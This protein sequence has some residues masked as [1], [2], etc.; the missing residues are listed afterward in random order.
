VVNVIIHQF[1]PGGA[2][3]AA[4]A[5]AQFQQQWATYRKLV[6]SDC[7]GHREVG[8]ILRETLNEF[9]RRPFASSTLP[10]ATPA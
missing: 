9:S 1:Q 10:A 4:A 3:V 6:E 5:L 2:V 7:L 8:R